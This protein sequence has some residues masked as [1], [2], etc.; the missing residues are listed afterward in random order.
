MCVGWE[1]VCGA[2]KCEVRC[3]M[4]CLVCV[5]EVVW[6]KEKVNVWVGVGRWKVGVRCKRCGWV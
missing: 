4:Q 2:L 3:S 5:G 1:V 6:V